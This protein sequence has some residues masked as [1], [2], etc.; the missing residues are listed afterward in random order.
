MLKKLK[1]ALDGNDVREGLTAVISVKLPN[2]QFEGQTKGKLGNSEAEGIVRQIVN[3]QLTDFLERQPAIAKKIILKAT[4]AARAKEAARQARNLVRRKSALEAGTLPGKLSDCQERSPSK[5]ELYIVEGDSAGGSC[6]QGRDRKFQAVLPIKGKILNVEKA[7]FDKMLSSEEIRTIITALGTGIGEQ[8]FNLEKLRYHRI[9]LLADADVD[10]AHIRTLLLTFFYRQMPA[11][12]EAGYLYIGQ[13]PLYRAKRGKQETYLKNEKAL[14]DFLLERG[15]SDTK[16][17]TKKG[18]VSGKTLNKLI[19][20]IIKYYGLLYKMKRY[21]DPRVVDAVVMAGGLTTNNLK[22]GPKLDAE[23]DKIANYIASNY[24]GIVDFKVDV[25][26]DPET[27]ESN[28]TYSTQSNGLTRET[29]ID[30]EFLDSPDM[31]VLLN[32]RKE[33]A[34]IELPAKLIKE[35][36]EIKITNLKQVKDFVLESGSKGQEIQRYKGLGEN[37]PP[38]ALG[39]NA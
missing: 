33:T 7:R 38:P 14:E 8:D 28:I 27:K 12:V 19:R 11:L 37:E 1:G 10:G 15:I 2:P 31:K 20:S 24:P 21:G 23:L 25:R 30:A 4:E 32:I 35:D 9:I 39:N 36:V 16:L 17:V 26:K 22:P 18:S 5:C 29:I 3:D 6:K 34:N 13:P